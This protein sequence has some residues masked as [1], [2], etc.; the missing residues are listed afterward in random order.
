MSRDNPWK[1]SRIIP[2]WRSRV[3]HAAAASLGL[4]INA[5]V[6]SVIQRLPADSHLGDLV[7]AI[8][9]SE[10]WSMLGALAV[11][12]YAVWGNVDSVAPPARKE[13]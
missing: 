10:W 2:W 11:C 12:L 8:S 4:S 13:T 9:L 6:Q 5:T 3:A 1:R 7:R